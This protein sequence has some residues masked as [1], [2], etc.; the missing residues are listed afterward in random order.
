[1]GRSRAPPAPAEDESQRSKRRRIASSGDNLETGTSGQNDGKRALYHC[2]YCNKDISGIVRI[3]CAKCPDFDLCIECFSVGAEVTPHKSNHDYRVMDSLSF[4]L[5]DPEW[6]TDEEQLLLEAIE[7]YGLSFWTEVAEH[8]GTKSK[9]QC[10]DHYQKIYMNSPCFPLPEMSHAIG[11]TKAELLN[12][13]KDHAEGK[14]G[15]SVYG[16]VKVPKEEHSVS[17]L[18][19]KME[20]AKKDAVT[21]ANSLAGDSLQN[22][23][24]NLSCYN[25]GKTVSKGAQPKEEID[26]FGGSQGLTDD[27]VQNRSIVGEKPIPS[28]EEGES[29]LEL[30]G[31]NPKRQEFDPEY[32]VEAEKVL[33]EMEFKDNDSEMDRELKLR[34]L[35]IYLSRLDE[36]KRRNKFILERNLLYTRPQESFYTKEDKDLYLRFRVFMRYH[37]RQEHDELINGLIRER[38]LRHRIQELQE[39][40]AAGCRT[41][42]EAEQYV[43]EKRKKDAETNCKR[44]K[45]LAQVTASKIP[46]R[47]NR[48]SNKEREGDGSPG[49]TVDSL[50]P[51][52]SVGQQH[53]ASDPCNQT[54]DQ[55]GVL[56][57]LPWN[58][59]GLPGVQ[60][61]SVHEHDLCVQNRLHPALYLKMKEELMLGFLKG[62]P[63]KKTDAYDRF[64]INPNKVD[65]VYDFLRTRE[66]IQEAMPET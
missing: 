51:R 19:M 66:L 29:L 8:V 17:P 12:M 24:N 37:T 45:E 47:G 6:T 64:K 34:M 43:E 3:K 16:D 56:K 1:M 30:S 25:A 52:N 36:R 42:A 58:I 65:K 62:C 48:A 9:S 10:Y 39:Y 38:K 59:T 26:C 5:L 22:K 49:G 7:M 57:L 13:A 41:L 2:N 33:A 18:R 31:Y 44:P 40:R 28:G 63:M 46:Q 11:K 61:L 4:P 20:D 53:P 35:R 23:V 27:S 50:N 60:L 21:E 15:F 55:K 32:D 54:T 14:T